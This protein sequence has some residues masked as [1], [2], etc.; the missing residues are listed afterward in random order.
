MVTCP[1]CGSGE[2]LMIGPSYF[3]CLYARGDVFTDPATGYSVPHVKRCGRWFQTPAKTSSSYPPRC[4]CLVFFATTVCVDCGQTACN[5]HHVFENNRSLCIHCVNRMD[6]SFAYE[7]IP[8]FYRA[9]EVLAATRDPVERLIRW[10]CL[11][12]VDE[13]LNS[14]LGLDLLFPSL[15]PDDA[16]RGRTYPEIHTGHVASWF[17]NRALSSGLPPT[18]CYQYQ[19]ERVGLF[20]G[21]S[22]VDMPPLQA[23][24]FPNAG[25][26]SGQRFT[27]FTDIYILPNGQVLYPAIQGEMLPADLDGTVVLRQIGELLDL[28]DLPVITEEPWSRL[29]PRPTF[30]PWATFQT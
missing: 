2:V 11:T 14:G 5:Q 24:R 1:H 18:P 26:S 21:R 12:A 19:K 27:E 8:A 30:S 10:M 16:G 25:P 9:V 3:Q 7:Y 6:A 4:F 20:G 29:V 15:F 17:V 23:W 28:S 13:H 22:L